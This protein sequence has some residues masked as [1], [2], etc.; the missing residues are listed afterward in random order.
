MAIKAGDLRHPVDL[1]KPVTTLG[2]HNR[3]N[4]SYVK[5]ATV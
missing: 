1:L 3:R 2:E 5:Q 4:T